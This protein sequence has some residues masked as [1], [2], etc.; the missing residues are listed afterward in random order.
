MTTPRILFCIA[1]LLSLPLFPSATAQPA[2]QPADSTVVRVASALAEKS[3][4]IREV[5]RDFWSTNRTFLVLRPTE[6]ALLVTSRTAPENYT[7]LPPSQVPAFLHERAYLRTEYPPELG[8]RTFDPQ[9]VLGQDTIPALQPKGSAFFDRLDFYLHESFHGHQRAHWAETPGDTIRVG[10]GEHLADSTLTNDPA[11][12]AQGEVE[13]RILAAA[14]DV[15]SRDSLR[16][17]MR[18]YL[19][20]RRM[21][22]EGR[23]RVRAVERS[24]ERREGT[25]TYIGCHGAAAATGTERGI[26][27][28]RD[29][30]TTPLDSLQSFPEADARLLRWRQ[31]GTGAALCVVLD[32]LGQVNWQTEVAGGAALDRLVETVVNVD[33]QNRSKT[34]QRALHAFGYTKLLQRAKN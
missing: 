12:R 29:H 14:L 23:E 32:R 21:R 34:A 4:A 33:S 15:S 28:I 1:A 6:T 30:V 27:C 5:W 2:L 22:T 24:M 16:A 8:P 19:A 25:A 26:A 11:F 20:V 10:I 3:P 17:L 7:P 31:Y 13:R 9:Y 18:S